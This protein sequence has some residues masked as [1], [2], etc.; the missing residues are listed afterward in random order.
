MTGE[1]VHPGAGPM[2]FG[3]TVPVRNERAST[4]DVE[5]RLAAEEI[6]AEVVPEKAPPPTVVVAAH[7]GDGD[8]SGTDFLQLADSGKVLAGD[9]ARVLE[10][11]VEEVAHD[12]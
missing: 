4:P 2:L 8:A 1:A 6:D 5:V 3:E 12:E 11:E 7:E 9:D 10:P